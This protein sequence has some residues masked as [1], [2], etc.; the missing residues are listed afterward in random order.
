[1]LH[2][3]PKIIAAKTFNLIQQLQALPELEDF[4]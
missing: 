3:N 2:K 4:I 1:M